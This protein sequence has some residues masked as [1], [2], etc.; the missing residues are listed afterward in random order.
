[1]GRRRRAPTP[2]PT[3]TPSANFGGRE[4]GSR[5][6]GPQT[7]PPHNPGPAPAPRL[8]QIR[9]RRGG[10][11]EA[12][13]LP[14]WCLWGRQRGR[15]PPP[16]PPCPAAH[17]LRRLVPQLQVDSLLHLH[18]PPLPPPRPPPPLP[19]GPAAVREGGKGGPGAAAA[20]SASRGS[21]V[22]AGEGRGQP[23]PPA[24]SARSS[25]PFNGRSHTEPP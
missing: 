11:N 4:A 24:R 25:E 6:G 18:R 22:W 3:K 23:P 13:P 9:Q 8:T 1:M 5:R 7:P 12:G 20:A 19:G 16:A 15:P 10:G 21:R 2:T 17:L 14:A